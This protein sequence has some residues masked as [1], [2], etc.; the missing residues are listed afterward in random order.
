MSLIKGAITLL[1]EN[2]NLPSVIPLIIGKPIANC[3]RYYQT[4]LKKSGIIQLFTTDTVKEVSINI[5]SNAKYLRIQ[6]Y[7]QLLNPVNIL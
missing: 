1:V 3:Q 6:Q 5:T 7:H 2:F 4:I